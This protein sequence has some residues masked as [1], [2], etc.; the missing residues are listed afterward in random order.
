MSNYAVELPELYRQ[1]IQFLTVKT[2]DL[3]KN[4]RKSRHNWNDSTK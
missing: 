1:N 3:A 2:I 4:A